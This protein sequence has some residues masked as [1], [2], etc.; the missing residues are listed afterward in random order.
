MMGSSMR[1]AA[2]V[3]AAALTGGCATMPPTRSELTSSLDQVIEQAIAE[4]NFPGAVLIVG[5]RGRVLH[6]RAYGARDFST[7]A[8]PMTMDTVFD[9]ASVSKPAGAGLMALM[10]MEEGKL[11]LE[12]PV[13]K[14]IPGFEANGKAAVRVRELMTHSSG[15]KAYE[16]WKSVEADRGEATTKPN[17]LMARYAALPTIY[18]PR[19]GHVYSCL[20]FQTLAHLNEQVAGETMASFLGKRV[21][22]PMEMRDTTYTPTTEQLARTAPTMRKADGTPIVGVIHDP[23]AH[24]HGTETCT[25]GNAGLFSTGPDMARFCQLWL[26]QGSF[27]GR[28]YLKAG[29]VA[30]A[31]SN[32]LPQMPDEPYGLG[33][34]IWNGAPYRTPLNDLAE[35]ATFGH[36][37]Y[38]GTLL[39]MDKRTKTHVVFLTNRVLSPIGTEEENGGILQVRRRVVGTVIKSLPEYAEVS[40]KLGP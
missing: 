26:G 8:A 7:G 39:W 32:Q 35:N 40:E 23:L 6:Q 19:E 2:T 34:D 27:D 28:R 18:T 10:L 33:W 36:T 14:F 17:A 1:I 4:K 29:T 15:L 24:Y 12:D 11:S 9:M 37:G 21:F 38:T 22:V 5:Q 16:N 3:L 20:N 25:P 30:M 31:T 13:S